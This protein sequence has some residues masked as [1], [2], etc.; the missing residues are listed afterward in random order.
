MRGLVIAMALVLGVLPTAAPVLAQS[1]P[2]ACQFVLGF[3]AIH[4]L[5]PD[6]VGDCLEDENHNPANGDGLQHTAGGLLVWRKIDNWTAFTDGYHTWVNG[7]CGLVERLNLQ[8]FPFEANPDGLSVVD[9]PCAAGGTPAPTATSNVCV[10]GVSASVKY[11]Q[12]GGGLQ[13]LYVTVD[14]ANGNPVADAAGSA[15]VQY[16]TTSRDLPLPPTGADGGAAVSWYVGGP[17]G[18]VTI[19]V[20]ETSGGCTATV[21][22]SFQGRS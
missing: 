22:T 7:P 5:I 4:D 11:P 12:L 13:T 16:S 2:P 21:T 8:R 6:Q 20:T 18:T 10:A 1:A 14:D 15:H 9:A 3:K 19:T 17:R